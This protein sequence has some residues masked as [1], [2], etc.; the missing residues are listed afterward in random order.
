MVA[1]A[2]AVAAY[3]LT[4][5]RSVFCRWTVGT[6]CKSA[7]S[8]LA[9][10]LTRIIPTPPASCTARLLLTR[11]VT[12]RSHK[13]IFPATFAGSSTAPPSAAP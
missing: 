8:E 1:V 9:V 10:G 12:P 13:T 7:L 5:G 11:A 3:A 6:K 2:P 4:A